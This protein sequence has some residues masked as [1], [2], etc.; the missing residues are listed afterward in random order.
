MP[1]PFCSLSFCEREW[2]ESV[3]ESD[4]RKK[5]KTSNF[6]AHFSFS[7]ISRSKKPSHGRAP[8]PSAAPSRPP[9]ARRHRHVERRRAAAASDAAAG[10]DAAA[11]AAARKGIA[12]YALVV[13]GATDLQRPASSCFSSSSPRHHRGD[14]GGRARAASEADGVDVARGDQPGTA[15]ARV[16]NHRRRQQQHFDASIDAAPLDS[17]LRVCGE[18]ALL[19]R[20]SRPAR[21]VGRLRRFPAAPARD[22]HPRKRKQPDPSDLD[23]EG[24]DRPNGSRTWRL[25]SSGALVGWW[26]LFCILMAVTIHLKLS[27]AGSGSREARYSQWATKGIFQSTCILASVLQLFSFF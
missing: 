3:V 5:I 8:R 21:L 20:R 14:L 10:F 9:R 25:A 6:L 27:S 15:E 23:W 4:A 2:R 26:R 13:V 17:G 1:Q 19:R 24:G 22:P 18:A 7:L 16:V 11:F 12:S